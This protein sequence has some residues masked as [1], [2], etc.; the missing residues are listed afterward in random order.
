MKVHV[1]VHTEKHH[2]GK[3]RGQIMSGNYSNIYT[4]IIFIFNSIVVDILLLILDSIK[5]RK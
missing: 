3:I 1:N 2:N 5:E 4:Y